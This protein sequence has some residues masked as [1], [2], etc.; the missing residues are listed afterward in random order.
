MTTLANNGLKRRLSAIIFADVVNYSRMMGEDEVG[1][2]LAVKQRVDAFS[3]TIVEHSGEIISTAGDGVFMLFESAVDAVSFAL[4]IQKT[5]FALNENVHE[6]K[7][8][9]FRFGINLGDVL[10]GEN[11]LTGESIN[12]AAR[13]ESFAS[14]GRICIS[15][16]VYD[17]I[18]NKMTIG[19]EY[20]GAQ[21]F[22]NIKDEIEVFQLHED[23]A[24]AAMTAGGRRDRNEVASFKGDPIIDQSIVVLPFSFQG[25][26][27]DN[28]W[29]A[30]GLTEDITTSL[31]RFQQFFVISRGSAY[32]YADRQ[33]TPK[34]AAKELGV[35]YVVNGSVR[36]SGTR[37]RITIQLVDIIR[38]RTIWGEQ[39]NRNVDD[40][41]DL[42]DEITQ[43]IV[44][45]SAAKIEHAEIERL[46]QL[47]PAN[48]AAYGFVLQGQKY[49]FSYTKN[50]ISQARNLYDFALGSDPSYARA[51][52]AKS[53]T[54][55]LDWRYDWTDNREEALNSALDLAIHAIQFDSS[56]AR[57]FGELGF[58][59]L[60]RKEHDEAI[61]AYE[62]ALS[63]NPND[64]DLMSDMAD[65]L[66]HCGRSEEAV[67]LLKKAM[68][69]NPFYPD[70]YLWHLGGAYF[71]LNDYDL[72]IQTIKSM[73]NPTEGRRILAASYGHLGKIRE[74]E[75]QVK[76]ILIAHPNFNVEHW[77][78]VQPD[79]FE[80]D[81]DH[82]VEGLKKAGL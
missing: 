25:S 17:S 1:T 68:R 24:S 42:Q 12:I 71:N 45:A 11:E 79:K 3:K 62:R 22:K 19:Y 75:E 4:E 51:H 59:H 76:R 29:F 21:K 48:M 13:I 54:L 74:A 46:K 49:I 43:T 57:G 23:P 56:D 31:S 36:M 81:V 52:A 50:G 27:Q 30:D 28:S 32:V 16:P 61:S 7:Q 72:A 14:P 44:S 77:A 60:Y 67:E 39:Y 33:I 38:D 41:F 18:A 55:N 66:A 2:T 6:D 8:V 58:A 35:R 47:P 15:G 65:A 70:Q 63:R 64:A 78:S 80:A 82:F 37:I 34:E 53:R 69:L 9:V 5:I 20:L 10:F 40:L 26:D 73:Q